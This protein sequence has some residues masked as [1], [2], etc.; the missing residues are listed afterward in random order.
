L[1]TAFNVW[2]VLALEFFWDYHCLLLLLLYSGIWQV[3]VV[4]QATLSSAGVSWP[5]FSATIDKT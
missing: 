3:N 1:P 2:L 4:F 5:G